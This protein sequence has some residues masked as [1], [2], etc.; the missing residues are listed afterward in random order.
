MKNLEKSD[1]MPD[2]N[3]YNQNQLLRYYDELTKEEK[4]Q[5]DSQIKKIDFELMNKLYE[6][7][8]KNEIIDINNIS[9]L[10]IIDSTEK[11]ENLKTGKEIV[12]N[13]EYAVLLMAG[14]LG[15]RLGIEGPKGCLKLNI[16]GKL[17]SLFEIII[18]QL[19]KANEENNTVIKL[20]IMTSQNNNKQTIEF[21]EE[22]NYFNYSKDKII[23]FIQNELPILDVDGKMVLKNKSEVLFGP[24]GNGDVF[25]S[26]KQNH[27][28]EDMKQSNIKYVSFLTID[29]PLNE[30]VD[31]N[32]IG[33]TIN[34]NYGLSSKT[35]TK[36]SD[37][38][39]GWVFLKYNGKPFMLPAE[40]ATKE[41]TN[42]KQNGDYVYR[43]KNNA[44]H[45][46]SI[47][48]IEN[49]SNQKLKYHRAYKKNS[50]LDEDG[51]IIKPERPNSFKFEKFIFDAFMYADDMLLYRIKDEEFIAIKVIEDIKKI[52]EILNNK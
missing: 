32:F 45:L 15:S 4:Q 21:F 3:K 28:I 39:K 23:M 9:P 18:N 29:N 2:L 11:E 14:G 17:I 47:E 50:Y 48:N 27:L 8:F 7:S 24:N 26:L 34:N 40:Y 41:I 1:N 36:K 13:G 31:Y 5:L 33:A 20:Y 30:V 51:N 43:E 35:R 37:E 38:E 16:K 44:Y 22:N 42:I 10:K 49:F 6:D 52:E 25:D 19:K 46:I 12:K